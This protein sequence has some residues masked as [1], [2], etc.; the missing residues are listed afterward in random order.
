MVYRGEEEE[1]VVGE[2]VVCMNPT[3]LFQ[4]HNYAYIYVEMRALRRS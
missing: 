2:G 4:V 3:S 1:E